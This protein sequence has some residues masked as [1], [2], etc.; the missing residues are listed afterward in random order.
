MYVH[1]NYCA[2]MHACIHAVEF[3][4][5][6][7]KNKCIGIWTRGRYTYLT[8]VARQLLYE[9]NLK[10]AVTYSY[11]ATYIATQLANS[12]PVNGSCL[13]KMSDPSHDLTRIFSLS[14]EQLVEFL[15]ENGFASEV[16]QTFKGM[17]LI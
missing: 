13:A 5:L 3:T 7:F 15:E 1:T 4:C 12:E 8:D 11:I 9:R 14:C 2:C 17:D 10:L 6:L 16:C